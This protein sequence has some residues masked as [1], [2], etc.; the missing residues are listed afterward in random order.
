MPGETVRLIL[1]PQW[2]DAAPLLRLLAIAAAATTITSLG[3][4]INVAA[5]QTRRLMLS[6]ALALPVTIAAVWLGAARGPVGVAESIAIVNVALVLP[7]LWW[8]LRGLPG[9]LREYLGALRGPFATT[10]IFCV[11]LWT[12]RFGAEDFHWAIRLGV[13]GFAGAIA[14]ISLASLWPRLREEAR[15]V[16]GYLPLPWMRAK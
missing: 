11:G 7:K 10:A 4:A 14:L 3:Y 13:A 1:G 12:G 16:I 5:G 9:G 6:A 2:P 15:M 8:T